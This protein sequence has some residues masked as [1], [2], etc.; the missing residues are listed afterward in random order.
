MLDLYVVEIVTYMRPILQT[1]AGRPAGKLNEQYERA[2]PWPVSDVDGY[3]YAA[4]I[5][6]AAIAYK[7]TRASRILFS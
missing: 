4:T 3:V 7:R 5:A 2:G 1:C 6:V